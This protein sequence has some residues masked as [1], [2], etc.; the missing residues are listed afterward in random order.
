MASPEKI[1]HVLF[2]CLGNI[3][4]SPAA[5]A[6][7][8]A[9]AQQMPMLKLEVASC[10]IGNW[11]VGHSPDR[12]MQAA[13]KARGIVLNGKA[14]QFDLQFLDKYDYLF[15]AD[16]AVLQSLYERATTMEQKAKIFLMT[17]YSQIYPRQEIP[18]PY[19]Q[20]TMAF[21]LVLDML[22]D[23]CHGFLRHLLALDSRC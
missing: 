19:Y 10:G 21:E 7:L 11:H 6:M 23:S 5:E 2:V 22:E 17:E 9:F 15:A 12:R 4:R 1:I 13:S 14:Q 8:S 3:C 16:L 18:D 20:P